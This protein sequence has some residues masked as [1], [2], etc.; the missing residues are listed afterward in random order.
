MSAG[1]GGGSSSEEKERGKSLQRL[2]PPHWRASALLETGCQSDY[3]C[4]SHLGSNSARWTDTLAKP[5]WTKG[6]L[7][8]RLAGPSYSHW[9]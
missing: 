6:R 5:K 7:G 1:K 2:G 3:V 8:P 9:Q 4:P